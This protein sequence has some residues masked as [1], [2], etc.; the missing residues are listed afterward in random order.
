MESIFYDIGF[1]IM[2]ATIGGFF[3]RLIKQPLIPFYVIAG[4]FLGPIFG[5]V[6]NKEIILTLSEFGIA[7][8]LFIV[9][10]EIDFKKL[11]KSDFEALTAA[12]KQT[13]LFKTLKALCR[14]EDET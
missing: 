5:L 11:K 1:I 7:F 12:Q 2:I 6:A 14:E 3:A 4:L 13:L 8:L 9:G 10:L